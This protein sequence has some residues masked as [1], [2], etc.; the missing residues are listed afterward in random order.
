[1]NEETKSTASGIIHSDGTITPF[2]EVYHGPDSW[3]MTRCKIQ[4]AEGTQA[5]RAEDY[6]VKYYTLLEKVLNLTNLVQIDGKDLSEDEKK[7]LKRAVLI[8]TRK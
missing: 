3:E 1:M 7:L 4:V 8:A 2:P 5:R 6:R